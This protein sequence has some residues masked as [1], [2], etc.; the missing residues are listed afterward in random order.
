[1]EDSIKLNLQ[2]LAEKASQE[3]IIIVVNGAPRVGKDTFANSV[4][5]LY[6]GAGINTEVY[7]TI[8][9][10]KE[11]AARFYGWD[12]EKSQEARKLLSDLK[13]AGV[14]YNNGSIVNLVVVATACYTQ[15]CSVLIVHCREPEEIEAICGLFQAC[16]TVLITRDSVA[17]DPSN[18]A[19]DLNNILDFP[20]DYRIPNNSTLEEFEIACHLVAKNI[21]ENEFGVVEETE[22]EDIEQEKEAA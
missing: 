18:D 22:Q 10:Y 7:S 9:P 2:L 19:D 17:E 15:G 20:Y 1:M 14:Q 6:D 11:V 21:L 12:G 13:A 5:C 4:N 8:E 16:Y 3:L